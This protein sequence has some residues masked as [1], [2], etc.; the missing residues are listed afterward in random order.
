MWRSLDR[1]SLYISIEKPSRCTICDFIEYHSTCFGRSFRPSSGVQDYTY[2]NT[3]MS[4]KF[5]D[6]MLA[7]T[8]WNLVP[9]SK[10]STNLY[11]IHLMLYVQSWTPDD[12]RK[13][14]PKHEEWFDIRKSVHHHT[15]SNKSTTKM[16]Q[17]HKFITLRVCVA[18]HVSGVSPP[19]IRSIQLQ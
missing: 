11:D 7:G 16:Q 12:E 2:S 9:S 14:R 13:D 8:R 5:V 18:E 19:I 3:Y 10:Q 15:I 6:C 17:F 4:Y 1:A